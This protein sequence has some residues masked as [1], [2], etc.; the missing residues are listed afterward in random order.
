MFDMTNNFVAWLAF[1]IVYDKESEIS[2]F[3]IPL[4]IVTI[5]KN[6]KKKNQ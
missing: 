6:E 2:E 3:Q 5:K 1:Y 4:P